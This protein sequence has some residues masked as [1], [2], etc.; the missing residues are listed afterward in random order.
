MKGGISISSSRPPDGTSNCV[1]IPRV[2]SATVLP[3][4][5]PRS[6]RTPVG[7]HRFGATSLAFSTL[8]TLSQM[9]PSLTMHRMSAYCNLSL[10]FDPV[11]RDSGSKVSETSKTPGPE[12][13]PTRRPAV[14]L[15]SPLLLVSEMES[16][17]LWSFLQLKS[18]KAGCGRL[19]SAL[20]PL[21]VVIG[22]VTS[23]LPRQISD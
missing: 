19:A 18:R 14:A 7:H 6:V 17:T 11:N 23:T 8:F 1:S 4:D 2:R 9:P 3:G 13:H 16:T 22:H 21:Q 20:T 5:Q 10:T 12:S 15:S